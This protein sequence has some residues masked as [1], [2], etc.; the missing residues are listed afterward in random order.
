M[1]CKS[2]YLVTRFGIVDSQ[3]KNRFCTD[4]DLQ[5]TGHVAIK[6][7]S[8]CNNKPEN[9]PEANFKLTYEFSIQ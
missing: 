8:Q 9:L 4:Q 2:I 5:Y 3:E 6:S 7:N 1:K